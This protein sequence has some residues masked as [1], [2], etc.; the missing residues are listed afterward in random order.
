LIHSNELEIL[1]ATVIVSGTTS[2]VTQGCKNVR[3]KDFELH[4]A[5]I[6]VADGRR[7]RLMIEPRRCGI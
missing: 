5:L 4:P 6:A 3:R 7:A 1:A 2:A